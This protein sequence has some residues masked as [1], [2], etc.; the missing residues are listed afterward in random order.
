MKRTPPH[1]TVEAARACVVPTATYGAQVWYTGQR[2]GRYITAVD[3]ALKAVPRA[4]LLVWRTAPVPALHQESGVPSAVVAL[5][6][7][8]ISEAARFRRLERPTIH[9]LLPERTGHRD[10]EAYH[11]RFNHES[12]PMC[13]CGG[14][15]GT[16]RFA[17]CAWALQQDPTDRETRR[18]LKRLWKLPS[19]DWRTFAR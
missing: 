4:V 7:A 1:T 9:R 6:H 13:Q 18:A 19:K 3:R 12:Y 17:T 8:S 2:Q 10:F 16:R 5:E 14:L 15:T 11:L